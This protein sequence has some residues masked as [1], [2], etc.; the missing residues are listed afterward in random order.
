M[1]HLTIEDRGRPAEVRS[2]PR[3]RRPRV[4]FQAVEQELHDFSY[5][6]SHDLAASFRHA[7]E[8][9]RL[10]L[11]DLD[12]DLT[13]RQ[14]AYAEHIQRANANCQAMIEQLLVYSRAQQKPLKLALEGAT[15]TM[16]FALLKLVS[17]MEASCAEVSIEPLG[18]ACADRML[19][20]QAFQHLLDNA[21][22]FRRAG[23]RPQVSVTP[24]HSEAA[25][26]VRVRDNG[27]G[28]DPDH[29]ERAFRMFQRL[30]GE[31]AYP[32]VGAGLAISRR[33][34]RRHGGDV[35]FLDCDPPGACV[36]LWL[37]Q[38]RVIH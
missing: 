17:A 13:A 31:A 30:N 3:G 6:V 19:I 33:I 37:P 35:A 2:P 20:G 34:A 22:K 8:F 11:G 32:G 12:H 16:Q 27:I 29:R 25:W 15:P 9:S 24:A 18:D 7:S 10:L 14:H 21:I 23:V 38:R 28:V 26:R 5:I 36:E 4:A 1:N